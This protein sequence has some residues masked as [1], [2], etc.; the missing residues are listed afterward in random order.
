M[1]RNPAPET[2]GDKP[3]VSW[4][5]SHDHPLQH[6][7]RRG[8]SVVLGVWSLTGVG[9]SELGVSMN[10]LEKVLVVISV[11]FGLVVSAQSN[12][13]TVFVKYRGQVDLDNFSCSYVDSSFVHRICYRSN[14]NYVVVLLKKTYY[15]YCRVPASLVEQWLSAG[16]KGRYYLANVKGRYDCRQGGIPAG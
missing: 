10:K 9:L 4:K 13:E 7:T 14:K 2:G 1:R 16:S 5:R 11:L 3:C 8:S 12:A 6:V 15:H